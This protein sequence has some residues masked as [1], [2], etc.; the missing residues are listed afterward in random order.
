MISHRDTVAWR[1]F[2]SRLE[3]GVCPWDVH[4]DVTYSNKNL[5]ITYFSNTGSKGGE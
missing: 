2:Y 1:G 3:K 5:E 4:F